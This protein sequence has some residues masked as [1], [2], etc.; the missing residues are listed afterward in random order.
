MILGREIELYEMQFC[1]ISSVYEADTVTQFAQLF[2][3]PWIIVSNLLGRARLRIENE[4]AE[5]KRQLRGR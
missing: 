1:C 3:P 4:L 5:G 2:I